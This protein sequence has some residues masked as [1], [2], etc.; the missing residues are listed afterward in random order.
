[1]KKMIS[2]A[3]VLAML[4][5]MMV[6]ALAVSSPVGDD[7]VIVIDVLQPGEI[8]QFPS[9]LVGE[10]ATLLG[11]WDVYLIHKSTG[12][13]L[14]KEETDAY[15][16]ANGGSIQVDF[17]IQ[18]GSNT[19]V[20]IFHFYDG[21][22]HKEPYSGSKAT[23]VTTLSPFAIIVKSSQGDKPVV[24][25]PQT[26]HDTALWAGVTVVMAL[27]AGFCFARARKKAAE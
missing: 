3:A 22:W 11:M 20:E 26:G 21:T 9:S 18:V 16:A 17:T 23:G 2:I 6:P 5:V 19:V 4:F 15:I 27:C 14:T 1:M 24:P 13:P 7:V 25:S 10:G 12:Q 8:S